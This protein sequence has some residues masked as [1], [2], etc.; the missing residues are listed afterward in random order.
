MQLNEGWAW[1]TALKAQS[2]TELFQVSFVVFSFIFSLKSMRTVSL[3]PLWY[4]LS[5]S[6]KSCPGM[7]AG[8]TKTDLSSEVSRPHRNHVDVS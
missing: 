8:C 2:L 3:S 7:G 5:S 6:K 4:V 1:R